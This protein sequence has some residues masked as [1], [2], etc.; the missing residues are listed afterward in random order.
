MTGKAFNTLDI[1]IGTILWL[2]AEAYTGRIIV[3]EPI[4]DLILLVMFVAFVSMV[5]ENFRK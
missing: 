4:E 3:K 2:A 1:V 5:A